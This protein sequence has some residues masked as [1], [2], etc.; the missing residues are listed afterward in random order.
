MFSRIKRLFISK[1]PR[2]GL[3]NKKVELCIGEPW[4]FESP[5]GQGKLLG[6]IYDTLIANN[7]RKCIFIKTTP[8]INESGNETKY[9]V[10]RNRSVG[11]NIIVELQNGDE[12]NCNFIFNVSGEEIHKDDLIK[13][14]QDWSDKSG[15]IGGMRLLR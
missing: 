11:A 3:I 8:F 5:D 2:E 13:D 1:L 15:L 6:V 12:A 9:I 4:D 14:I 10:A 7:G